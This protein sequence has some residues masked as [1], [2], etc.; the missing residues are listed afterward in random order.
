MRRLVVHCFELQA[1]WCL[2]LLLISTACGRCAHMSA[3]NTVGVCAQLLAACSSIVR[4]CAVTSTWEGME[5]SCV[6]DYAA[7]MHNA[8]Q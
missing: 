6:A 1:L 8:L 3:D 2:H 7:D 5:G 4:Q